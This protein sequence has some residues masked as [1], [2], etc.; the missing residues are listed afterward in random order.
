[1]VFSAL[2]EIPGLSSFASC[3]EPF[4]HLEPFSRLEFSLCLGVVA[5]RL[6]GHGHGPAMVLGMVAALTGGLDDG[7]TLQQL[8][9]VTA[10]DH[11]VP[12][13]LYY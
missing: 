8:S 1:L 4:S 12:L 2:R 3:P 9:Q 7:L 5:F 6:L 13:Q 10:E 11:F